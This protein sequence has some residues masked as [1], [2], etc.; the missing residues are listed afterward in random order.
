[1]IERT[2][3]RDPII[4]DALE[5]VIAGKVVLL[6]RAP[7]LHRLS[8][9]AFEVV[10]MSDSNAIR[11]HPCVCSAFNADFDGDQMAV[12]LPLSDSAQ[13]EARTLLL[14]TRNL[15]SPAS[16]EPTVSISQEMVL[17]LFYLTQADRA[18]K[19]LAAF[20]RT[21]MMHSAPSITASSTC[22]PGCLSVSLTRRSTTH[23]ASSGQ[24]HLARG[25]RRRG[26]PHLE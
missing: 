11:L 17:G 3:K 6:N 12:H 20:S 10:W 13:R 1:M 21:Q 23:R 2:R 22:I 16:G 7:T 14:S 4:W 9:Q 25:S 19:A 24:R 8:I 18:R 5:E 26:P 15:R